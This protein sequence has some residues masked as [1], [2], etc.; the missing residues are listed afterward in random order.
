MPEPA[1]QPTSRRPIADLFR[2][3]ARGTVRVCVRLGVHPD[4][5]SYLSI[6]AAAGAATSFWQAANH[7]WLLILGP[8]FCYLRLWFNMLDGMVALASGKASLRGEILNE[9]P[10]RVSDVLI[11]AG[12]A[13]SGLC[14]PFV[15]YWAAILALFTAY[16]GMFGQAVGVQREFSGWMSKPWRMV[17]L[18]VGAWV[19]LGMFWFWDT[20]LATPHGRLT[21]L[22]WTCAVVIAGCV[23]TCTLRLARILHALDRKA[24]S[25][26]AAAP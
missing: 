23:Q 12:V 21:V 11:F 16:I 19:A 8:A 4:T 7:P 18:H 3:T 2:A 20:P 26:K 17:T 13:H 22:D 6:V 25:R 5:V 9:V 24:A 1:Y 14:S 15:A 10:D